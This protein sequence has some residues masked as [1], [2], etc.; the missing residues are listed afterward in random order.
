M[1][2]ALSVSL[3]AT[4]CSVLRPPKLGR[5]YAIEER[6]PACLERSGPGIVKTHASGMDSRCPR[7]DNELHDCRPERRKEPDE[8]ESKMFS[9]LMPILNG[10]QVLLTVSRVGDA[11]I[12]VC[13]VPPEKPSR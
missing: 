10:R 2:M 6:C 7:V 5:I 11:T 9:E 12:R 3:Q 13:V 1:P 8:G 4:K